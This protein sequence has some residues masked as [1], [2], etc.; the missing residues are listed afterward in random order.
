M[1]RFDTHEVVNQPPPLAG[2]NVFRGDIALVDA[3][4]REGAPWAADELAELGVRAGSI[5]A[6]ELGRRANENPPVL[7]NISPAPSNFRPMF[8]CRNQV[9]RTR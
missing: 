6:Q 3:L 8:D 1:T 9:F 4:E 2:Y 7:L 5:E